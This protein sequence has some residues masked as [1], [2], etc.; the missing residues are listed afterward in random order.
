MLCLS[1]EMGYVH[2]PFNPNRTPGWFPFRPPYWFMYVDESNESH[3]APYVERMLDF[4]YPYVSLTQARSARGIAQQ[5]P[6]VARSVAYRLGGRSL[7]I[8]DPMA[9][10]A[11]PWL[12][13]RFGARV[14]VTIRNPAA[15]VGSIKRLN[16]GFDYERNWLPQDGLMRDH[17]GRFR[18]SFVGYEGEVDL[19]G[20]GILLWEVLYD[21]VAQMR[22]QHEDWI[23]VRHEDLARDPIGGFEALYR[24][25]GLRWSDRV[26]SAVAASA[27]ESNP[28]DVP[29]W[30]RRVVKRDSR[31][32]TMS[33]RERLTP[34]ELARVRAEL[35][36]PARAFYEPDE[37]E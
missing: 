30:R 8:K 36:E 26:E 3:Y 19:V 29:T 34:Q 27:S 4:R 21:F 17:L 12:A 5:L 1:G 6:E 15:F 11:S 9:L 13:K 14:V 10:F 20:E 37:W 31:A 23:F 7:L 35:V 22:R 32:A 16:W 33:Y 24:A 18:E 28:K 25:L 2:E